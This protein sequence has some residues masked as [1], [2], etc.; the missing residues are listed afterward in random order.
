MEVQ[1]NVLGEPLE[2]CCLDPLT[3]WVRDG[4]CANHVSDTGM[5]HICVQVNTEFLVYSKAQGNDLSTPTEFFPGL[6]PG[7]KWCL[8]TMRWLQAVKDNQAPPV[9]LRATSIE[10]LNYVPLPLLKQ[11]ACDVED[12]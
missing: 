3:G 6:K 11:L 5:H 1:L 12:N 10:V 8:C 2:V 4:Y 7:D 9:F